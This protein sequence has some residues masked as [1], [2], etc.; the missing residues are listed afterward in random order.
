MNGWIVFCVSLGTA[1]ATG[2]GVLPVMGEPAGADF[3]I[4]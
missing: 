4:A 3:R 2:L 1:L